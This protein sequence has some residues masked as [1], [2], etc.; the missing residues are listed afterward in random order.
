MTH[1]NSRLM[2]LEYE[3]SQIPQALGILFLTFMFC[4]SPSAVFAD[5]TRT[6][7]PRDF[8]GTFDTHTSQG[9]KFDLFT[10]TKGLTMHGN[11]KNKN[12]LYNGTIRG[13]LQTQPD[14]TLALLY[15]TDQPGLKGNDRHGSGV[16][17]MYTDHT[18]KA[19]HVFSIGGVKGRIDWKG[20]FSPGLAEV[21]GPGFC[22]A[23]S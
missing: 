3:I 9:A 20:K 18:F 19:D 16:M 4:M 23:I 12:P 8:Y 5:G 2:F 7:N 22:L 6:S 14:G 13:D 10:C 21:Y 15:V 1:S 11:F 17:Q